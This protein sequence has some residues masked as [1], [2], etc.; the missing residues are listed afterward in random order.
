VDAKTRAWIDLLK[1]KLPAAV[2]QDTA[3][4]TPPTQGFSIL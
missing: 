1:E 2:A 4:F 3:F